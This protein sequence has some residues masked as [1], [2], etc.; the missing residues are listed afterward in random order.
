MLKDLIEA[1]DS[2]WGSGLYVNELK[3]SKQA[4][5]KVIYVSV[6]MGFLDMMFD[7]R[8]FDSLHEVHR[9]YFLSLSG[10]EYVSNPHTVMSVDPQS[11]VVDVMLGAVETAPFRKCHQN[12]GKQLK[13]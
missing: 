6:Y 1:D 10:E 12:R 3:V 9:R 5:H 11:N 13:P 2:C 8:P 4:W 7:F